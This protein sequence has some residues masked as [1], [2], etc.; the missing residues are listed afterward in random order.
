MFLTKNVSG[1]EKKTYTDCSDFNVKNELDRKLC[2]RSA[3]NK[4]DSKVHIMSF[5]LFFDGTI[6]LF[7]YEHYKLTQS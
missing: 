2:L 6:S 1:D 7:C 5:L 4:F 3:W